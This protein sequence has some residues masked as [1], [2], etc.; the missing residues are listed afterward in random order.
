MRPAQEGQGRTEQAFGLCLPTALALETISEGKGAKGKQ[1]WE[2]SLPDWVTHLASGFASPLA[3]E[4][5]E[6][7][8]GCELRKQSRFWQDLPLS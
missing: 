4:Q 8:R 6:D 7:S 1:G 3:F 2:D 5:M